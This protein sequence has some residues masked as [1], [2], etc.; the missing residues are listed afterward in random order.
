MTTKTAVVVYQNLPQ[1]NDG[2]NNDN[3]DTPLDGSLPA[4]NNHAVTGLNE[5]IATATN[6]LVI[7][8][9]EKRPDGYEIV[10]STTTT[11]TT[12]HENAE[13][14]ST[15]PPSDPDGSDF[16]ILLTS[17]DRDD[18][19]ATT[20]GVVFWPG[21]T[22]I[23]NNLPEGLLTPDRDLLWD[24]IALCIQKVIDAKE[25]RGLLALVV[26]ILVF[27]YIFSIF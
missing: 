10:T 3:I 7:G 23:P 11:T 24:G 26:T 8:S 22:S 14:D 18:V 5:R 25:D 19:L 20:P 16:I 6:Q 1:D 17:E 15:N 2:G 21:M 12:M 13:E 9:H 27:F 4:S